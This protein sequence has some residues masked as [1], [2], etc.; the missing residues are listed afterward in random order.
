[1]VHWSPTALIFV[2]HLQYKADLEQ[3]FPHGLFT[4][5]SWLEL[6][7]FMFYSQLLLNFQKILYYYMFMHF[8]L[9][10]W[11]FFLKKLAWIFH[12]M[13][14]SCIRKLLL[15]IAVLSRKWFTHCALS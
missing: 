4:A 1:M 2:S 7:D 13:K 9:V 10:L 12:M 6:Y 15:Q 11:S 5:K 14:K 3:L 8:M